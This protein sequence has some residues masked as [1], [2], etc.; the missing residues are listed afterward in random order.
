M[1]NIGVKQISTITQ[2]L[3]YMKSLSLKLK[4]GK[5]HI[6]TP[7]LFKF[8]NNGTILASLVLR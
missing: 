3:A 6:A 1:H 8:S 5:G 7:S 4:M 2:K